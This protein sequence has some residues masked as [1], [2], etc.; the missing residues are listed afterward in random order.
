MDELRYCLGA[1]R[2][3]LHPN[4]LLSMLRIVQLRDKHKGQRCFI[5]GNGPSLQKMD[6]RP[7]RGEYT[8]GLNRIYLLFDELGFATT[9]YVAVNRLVI[10]QCAQEI[11]SKVPSVMFIDWEA[12]DLIHFSDKTVYLKAFHEEPRFSTNI[13]RGIWQG[14][15]VTYVAMQIAYHMGFEKV[16]LIGVDHSFTVKGEP[17]QVVVGEA[18]DP[19][20]FSPEYFGKGFRWQLPDL[21]GSE[22][23]YRMAKFQFARAGREIVDATVGGK[24][25]IFPKTAYDSLFSG[26]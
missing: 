8:F 6:L 5:I 14:M 12:R 24:L 3:H 26:E 4:Y 1:F 10:E 25:E 22:L 17:H 15:T 19:N 18:E 7:L 16:I 11:M 21:Y 13:S 2:R 9:Y 23:A 20:H